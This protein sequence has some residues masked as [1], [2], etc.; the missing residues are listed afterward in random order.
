MSKSTAVLARKH[1]ARIIALISFGHAIAHFYN[2]ILTPLFPWI[3]TSFNLT[4]AQL[5]FLMTMYFAVS[6][7]VQLLAGFLVDKYGGRRILF[8][9]LACLA[10]SAL[11]MAM[12]PNYTILMLGAMLAGLGNSVF[13]PADFSLL[14]KYVSTPRLGHAYS[15]HGIS[16]NLG[17]AIAPIF[18]I[19]ICNL[20]NWRV[21]LIAASCLPIAVLLA[22]FAYR[23]CFSLDQSSGERCQPASH[24]NASMLSFLKLKAIWVCF[25]FFLVSAIALGGI[26]S[27]SPTGLRHIYGISLTL[28]TTAFTIYMLGSALGMVWGGFLAAKTLQ[29]ERIIA[30]AF[31]TAGISACLIGSGLVAPELAVILMAV[32]GLGAGVAAPSRD[33]LIRAA[34]PQEAMGRVYGIVYSGL[35]L[36][37]AIAPW[38]FGHLMDH[39]HPDLVFYS[40]GACQLLAILTAI[41]VKS[42]L[43]AAKSKLAVV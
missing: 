26:Q 12:A 14:N 42:T 7:V 43:N 1:D 11:V 5:G 32:T 25:G 13:H 22:L 40:I 2:L 34:A 27:F 19:G 6:G 18:L 30:L 8:A 15:M 17:W 35:E 33:F 20:A 10:L 21:A 16:G 24:S 39:H 29:H 28:A 31:C 36:G 3:K 23:N 37:F 38:L 9:G 4:W 41:G